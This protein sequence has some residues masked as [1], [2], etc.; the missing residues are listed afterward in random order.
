MCNAQ[1]NNT[2]IHLIEFITNLFAYLHEELSQRKR[3]IEVIHAVYYDKMY[4]TPYSH[5][6]CKFNRNP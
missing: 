3:V 6:I 5:A 4:F 1:V 2:R